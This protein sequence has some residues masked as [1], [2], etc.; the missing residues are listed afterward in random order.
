MAVT[1]GWVAA[2][3]K[4]FWV[5]FLLTRFDLLVKGEI[6][7]KIGFIGHVVFQAHILLAWGLNLRLSNLLS[8]RSEE[9]A[10]ER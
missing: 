9:K 5:S 7:C 3:W 6:R 1:G 10:K 2:L 8:R 4:D